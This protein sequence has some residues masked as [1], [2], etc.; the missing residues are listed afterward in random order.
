[1]SDATPKLTQIFVPEISTNWAKNPGNN[2]K[3]T[4]QLKKTCN[5]VHFLKWKEHQRAFWVDK[6]DGNVPETVAARWVSINYILDSRWVSQIE[7]EAIQL[8]EWEEVIDLLDKE[9]KA[10]DL[11]LTRWTRFFTAQQLNNEPVGEW[12]SSVRLYAASCGIKRI[13]DPV[14]QNYLISWVMTNGLKKGRLMEKYFGRLKDLETNMN[15]AHIK[16]LQEDITRTEYTKT[17]GTGNMEK[18]GSNENKP[19]G[20]QKKMSS[21]QKGGKTDNK[22]DTPSNPAP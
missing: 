11:P 1:M 21:S 10:I 16:K 8:T 15:E 2:F 18:S 12:C 22:K 3:E 19:A 13:K 9:V 17:S 5:H 7:G 20:T 14:D 6:F 4:S